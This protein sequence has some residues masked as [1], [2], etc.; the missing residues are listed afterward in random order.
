LHLHHHFEHP[1]PIQSWHGE[2]RDNEVEML[3]SCQFDGFS[4]VFHCRDYIPDV[5]EGMGEGPPDQ[6]FII[7]NK[8]LWR[9]NVLF[10]KEK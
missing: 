4:P 6:V 2:I 8:D 3:F 1:P 7:D 9:L 10:S 5:T